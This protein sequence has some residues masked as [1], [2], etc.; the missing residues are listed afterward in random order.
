M[1][2]TIAGSKG[3]VGKSTCC[4]NLAHEAQI[5]TIIELDPHE[6][7]SVIDAGH[8]RSSFDILIPR[9]RSELLNV[10]SDYAAHPT[11]HCF[12]DCGGFDSDLIRDA[13]GA[14]DIVLTPATESV[15]DLNG[16]RIF[17]TVL[18]DVSEKM[19]VK[20]VAHVFPY[21]H[22]HAKRKFKD[23]EGYAESL[24]HIEYIHYPIAHS[25]LVNIADETTGVVS[26]LNSDS[27]PA[28]QFK[29]LASFLI[30]QIEVLKGKESA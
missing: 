22:H 21:K 12:V 9:N 24:G 28:R 8:D 20:I 15:K 25:E 19:D 2:V 18:R 17:N 30:N 4:A 13:I 11:N 1:I 16:L 3:G 7:I 23:L 29:E 6:S 27:R 14:A 10:F 26:S 5:K